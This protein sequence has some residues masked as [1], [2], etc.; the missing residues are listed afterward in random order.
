MHAIYLQYNR[1]C[2]ATAEIVGSMPDFF[3]RGF[4]ESRRMFTH[5]R[6]LRS[7]DRDARELVSDADGASSNLAN[8]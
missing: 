3:T 6:R 7:T 5:R 4:H 8:S 1:V 2:K